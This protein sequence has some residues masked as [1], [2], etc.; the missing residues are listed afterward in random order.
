[1]KA[2]SSGNREFVFDSKVPF[3]CKELAELYAEMGDLDLQERIF[4]EK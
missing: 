4:E 2:E 1:M 3:A